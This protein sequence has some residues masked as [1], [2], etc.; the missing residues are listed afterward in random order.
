M[1]SDL[2]RPPLRSG[3][4]RHALVRPG[5]LWTEVRVVELTGSSNADVAGA[6]RSGAPEGLIVVA[7]E[8]RAGRGRLD[9]SWVSPPRAGLTFSVLLRPAPVPAQHWGWLSM[10]AGV[11]TVRAVRRLGEIEAGL[12]WPNDLLIG[13]DRK[14]AAGLL[15]EVAAG[16]EPAVVVGVG[17]NVSTRPEELPR[18]DATSL[19]IEGAACVDREPLLRAILRE[20]AGDYALWREAAGDPVASGLRAVYRES[21]D[22]LGRRVRVELPNR[23]TMLGEAVDIDADGRLVV[24]PEGGGAPLTVAAG[25]VVHASLA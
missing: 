18:A 13:P 8:Q 3:S 5:S 23:T 2:T 9:R 16:P 17:L 4:L 21:C 24:D 12:K 14:K 25:D 10:L 1:F 6:A 20:F 11:A 22:T 7:E 15:A 19:A